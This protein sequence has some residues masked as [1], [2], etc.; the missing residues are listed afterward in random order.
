M[1]FISRITYSG[2]FCTGRNSVGVFTFLSTSSPSPLLF[3]GSSYSPNIAGYH[4]NVCPTIVRL[5]FVWFITFSGFI[6]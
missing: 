4:F 3:F 2:V 5:L 1:K 6:V